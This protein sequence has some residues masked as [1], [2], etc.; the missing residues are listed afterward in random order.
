[1]IHGTVKV[2]SL[3]GDLAG[4]ENICMSNGRDIVQTSTDGSYTLPQQPEDRF[5]EN[6]SFSNLS[7]HW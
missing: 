5:G 1:M 7:L 6:L 3:N 4:I 2:R